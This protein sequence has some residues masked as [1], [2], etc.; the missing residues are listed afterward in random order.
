M[1]EKSDS[2]RFKAKL[3]RL[4]KKIDKLHLAARGNT[5]PLPMI[6]MA[7]ALSAKEAAEVRYDETIRET[8]AKAGNPGNYGQYLGAWKSLFSLATPSID[9]FLKQRRLL[10]ET[11]VDA[12][13]RG[14]ERAVMSFARYP[15]VPRNIRPAAQAW[16][17]FVSCLAD[18]ELRKL[19]GEAEPIKIDLLGGRAA[20]VAGTEN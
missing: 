7:V 9:S 16:Q 5:L 10:A 3:D 1:P 19:K 8:I 14:I 11:T 15:V 17:I 18:L 20:A 13:C 6:S 2:N 12:S 4:A